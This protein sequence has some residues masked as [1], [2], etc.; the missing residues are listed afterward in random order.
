MSEPEIESVRRAFDAIARRDVRALVDEADP[1]IEF[2]PL[3]SVWQRNYR[4]HAG[5]EQWFNDVAEQWEEFNARID[6]VR[7][8]DDGGLLVRTYW[9]GRAKGSPTEIH[10]PGALVIHFRAGKATSLDV[11]LDE[12][13][14]LKA[15]EPDG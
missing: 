1:E 4:G 10:G 8:L 14:A 6:G 11:Y 15:L 9:H 7:E 2:H 12:A 3:L 5:V 13:H